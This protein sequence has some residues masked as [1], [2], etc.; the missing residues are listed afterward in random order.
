MVKNDRKIQ[1]FNARAHALVVDDDR[2]IRDLVCRYLIEHGY[3][4]MS[5][6]CAR[7]SE[8]IMARFDFDVLVLDVMMPGEDGVSFAKRIRDD[9]ANIP[10]LL[11]TALG[12]AEDRIKGLEVGVDDY[13][14]KPFEPR[15]LLLRLN[16]ILKRSFEAKSQN[17]RI[18]MGEWDYVSGEDV[19]YSDDMEVALTMNEVLLLDAF[20]GRI[21]DV[22]SR[23]ELAE[24]C[25]LDA[26]E[27]T[28][29][30]QI[31]R[32]RRKIEKDTKSPQYLQTVRGKGY[33]LRAEML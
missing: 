6:S 21:G 14:V 24:L 3:V 28:I 29:D 1:N 27:R 4:A 19:L 33:V 8:D 23:D 18:R 11:L 32:L 5:A 16:I 9:G 25:G 22:L 2:R 20:S 30:V 26:G 13:L 15:E 10:I 7:E 12:E 17:Y 31:T